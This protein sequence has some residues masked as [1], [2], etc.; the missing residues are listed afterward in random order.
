[1]ANV[2]VITG[3]EKFQGI[4]VLPEEQT[5]FQPGAALENIFSQPP[6]GNP[7]VRVRMAKAAGNCLKCGL[8]AGE[9]RIAQMLERCVKTRV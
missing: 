2:I 6:D 7:A 8:D 3:K 4:S 9:I 1:M 5:Q